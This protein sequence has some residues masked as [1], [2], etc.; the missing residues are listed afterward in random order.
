M[1][2]ETVPDKI[3]RFMQ[4]AVAF[5]AQSRIL[6]AELTFTVAALYGLFHVFTLLTR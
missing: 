2:E 5:L 3:C 1:K 6:A 4:D